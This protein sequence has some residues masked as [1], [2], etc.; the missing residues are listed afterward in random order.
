MTAAS[1]ADFKDGYEFER[2]VSDCEMRMDDGA[3][4]NT[5]V[6]RSVTLGSLLPY[7]PREALYT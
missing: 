7:Q 1:P 4:R 5:F 2:S 6:L 3:E